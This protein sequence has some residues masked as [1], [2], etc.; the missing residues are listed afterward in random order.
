M[1][2]ALCTLLLLCQPPLSATAQEAADGDICLLATKKYSQGAVVV[3]DGVAL[4][5]QAGGH[6][7]LA[8]QVVHCV[9]EGKAHS[10]GGRIVAPGA[11]GP[12]IQVCVKGRW[13]DQSSSEPANKARF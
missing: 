1:R 10:A 13:M 4:T 3:D 9:S 5:C 6:W 2:T 12:V 8:D 11:L 7:H